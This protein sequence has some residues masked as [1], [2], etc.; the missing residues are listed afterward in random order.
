LALRQKKDFQFQEN[1]GEDYQVFKKLGFKTG[2][3]K[4]YQNILGNKR[5]GLG[6]FNL[7]V[8]W[9]RKYRKPGAK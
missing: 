5:D 1:L 8:Y 4:F 6:A 2:V 7:A 9:Q 3:S